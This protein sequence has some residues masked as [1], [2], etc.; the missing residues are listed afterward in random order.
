[1]TPEEPLEQGPTTVRTRMTFKRRPTS[2]PP[3]IRPEWRVPLLLLM[4]DHCRGQIAGREQLHVL[5][6]AVLSA[7]SRRAL[8]A[9]LDGRLAPNVPLVQFE[10]ALDRALDR[11]IGLRLLTIN[12]HGRFLLTDLGRSI[13]QAVGSNAALF[14]RE[15]ELLAALPKSLSQAAIQR[16]LAQRRTP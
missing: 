1:M 4:V 2:V 7:G 5:N 3:D 8:I 6:S 15:R 10:P 16:A 12:S 14:V 9:A 13:V 11:C